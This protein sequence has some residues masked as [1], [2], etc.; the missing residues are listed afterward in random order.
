[1][2]DKAIVT[3]VIGKNYIEIFN[4]V[5]HTWEIYAKKCNA[6]LIVFNDYINKDSL[7]ERSAIWQKLLLANS[8]KLKKYKKVCYLDSD[9]YININSPSI[10]EIN[11]SGKIG[12][13]LHESLFY[14][15][16]KKII[17]E[18]WLQL[19]GADEESKSRLQN[20]LENYYENFGL[21]LKTN[22]KFNAG[23]LVFDPNLHGQ[24]FEKIYWNYPKDAIDQ[25]QTAVNFEL[26]KNELY[27]EIDLRFNAQIGVI[28][29][30]NYPYL[31]FTDDKG[32]RNLSNKIFCQFA[33]MCILN[34]VETN[35]FTH[36]AGVR[37]PM[38]LL[39]H[40]TTDLFEKQI[41]YEKYLNIICDIGFSN[42]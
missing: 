26:I 24:F 20:V 41:D 15:E 17:N 36:F 39:D 23:V 14:P 21:I 42:K 28:L 35:Y 18:R 32:I 9:I 29:S 22:L 10:F 7:N 30:Y 2:N 25:D 8:E 33:L 5:K 11:T 12:V 1:M 3:F 27:Q 31:N 4:I 6:D 38:L 40:I 34:I 19:M 13:V 37:W 16:C